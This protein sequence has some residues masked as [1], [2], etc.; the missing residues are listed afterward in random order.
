[1]ISS[2]SGLSE[3]AKRWHKTMRE[4]YGFDPSEI[5]LLNQAAQCLDRIDEARAEIQKSGAYAVD[6]YGNPRKHPALQVENDCKI[7]FIRLLKALDIETENQ[8]GPGRPS[9]F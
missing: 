9:T 6:R 8:R 1:M 2:S 5:E 4:Y 3:K 7:L